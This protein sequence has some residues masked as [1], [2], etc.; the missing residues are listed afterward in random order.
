MEKTEK[1]RGHGDAVLDGV[2]A[3][4]GW[5]SEERSLGL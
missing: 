1:G 5:E 4:V 3:L 2:S